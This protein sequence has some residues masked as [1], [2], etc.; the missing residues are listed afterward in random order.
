VA[1]QKPD[2]ASFAGDREDVIIGRL[3]GVYWA[4]R[5]LIFLA[6]TAADGDMVDHLVVMRLAS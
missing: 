3:I 2:S 5:P 6:A 1:E 4:F